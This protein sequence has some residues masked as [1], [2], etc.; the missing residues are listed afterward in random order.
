MQKDFILFVANV[1]KYISDEQKEYFTLEP[2]LLPNFLT[3]QLKNPQQEQA[4]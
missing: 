4:S 2:Y 3:F 1:F